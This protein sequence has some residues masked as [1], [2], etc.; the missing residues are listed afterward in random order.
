VKPPPARPPPS[1]TLRAAER[2]PE[3]LTIPILLGTA[4][5]RCSHC[6]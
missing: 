5:Q 1:S 4:G 3:R 2:S 6:F